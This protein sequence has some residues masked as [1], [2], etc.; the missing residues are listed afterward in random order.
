MGK[1]TFV[2]IAQFAIGA[3]LWLS[4]YAPLIFSDFANEFFGQAGYQTS[5]VTANISESFTP[6]PPT[7]FDPTSSTGFFTVF[8]ILFGTGAAA[9]IVA[10]FITGG[11]FAVIYLIPAAII[12]PLIFVLF[13]PLATIAAILMAVPATFPIGVII[14]AFFTILNMIGLMEWI[15]GG[16][17]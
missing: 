9:G 15:R 8:L 4:G 3:L 12:I 16:E 11:N 5:N 10:S 13:S 1:L 2:I 14:M 7:Q 6:T 17:L